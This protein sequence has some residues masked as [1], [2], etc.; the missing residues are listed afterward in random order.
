MSLG[1]GGGCVIMT[2]SMSS[3]LTWRPNPRAGRVGT[4]SKLANTFS[5]HNSPVANLMYSTRVAFWLV[6]IPSAGNWMTI[7]LDWIPRFIHDSSSSGLSSGN[8]FR[9]LMTPPGLL[10]GHMP[11]MF[12]KLGC[13]RYGSSDG[14]FGFSRRL[15]RAGSMAID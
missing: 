6:V 13:T 3:P 4:A 5:T 2:S 10:A 11:L 14:W 8:M 12:A 9:Q 15:F 7:V 1:D